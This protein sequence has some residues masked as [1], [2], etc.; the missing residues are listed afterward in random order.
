MITLTKKTT[1]VTDDEPRITALAAA[2]YVANCTYTE[3]L[4]MPNPAATLDDICDALPEVM[5]QVIGVIKTTPEL[6]KVLTDDITDRLWAYTAIEYARAEAGAGYSWVFDV[7]VE[8]LEKGGNPHTIR[9]DAL[10]VPRRI[11]EL[12]EQAGGAA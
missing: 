5:P 9:A 6:T 7:L 1:A 10:D 3:A 11:R 4:K 2:L 12:A 8:A